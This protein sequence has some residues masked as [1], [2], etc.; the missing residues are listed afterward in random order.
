MRAR[1]TPRCTTAHH[2]PPQAAA[3]PPPQ[4]QQPPYPVSYEAVY[5]IVKC[6]ADAVVRP[7]STGQLAAALSQLRAGAAAAGK[8]IKVRVSRSKF[9]GTTSF[10]CPGAFT[11]GRGSPLGFTQPY[12]ASGF[13]PVADFRAAAAAAAGSP[14]ATSAVAPQL[15]AVLIDKLD[16]VTTVDKSKW[17]VTAQAGLRIDRLQAWAEANGMSTERGAPSTYAELSI[18]GVLA[19]G[20]H[21][22]GYNITSNLVCVL[23]A[24]LC[25]RVLECKCGRCCSWHLAA[26]WRRAATAPA[27]TSPATWCVCCCGMCL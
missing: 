26:C 5:G 25:V 10:T 11:G 3:P 4:P 1:R 24:L 14:A 17:Q 2:P 13:T 20:G 15:V 12:A 19:T 16:Q 6:Y 22:T 27:T 8:A 18:G 9:H 23:C 7:T 21:G